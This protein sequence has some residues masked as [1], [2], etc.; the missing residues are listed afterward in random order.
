M[1]SLLI[2]Q[3]ISLLLL[4]V[5]LLA[6]LI[7][8]R[9]QIAYRQRLSERLG[10]VV[11]MRKGGIIL[12]AASV[13]EVMA[14][15]PVV[16]GILSSYPQMPLTI[17]TFTPT[18]SAQVKKQFGERVQ[19]CYIPLD[20]LLSV[21]LFLS[22]LKPKLLILMETELWP[23]LIHSSQRRKIPLLLINARLSQK[24]LGS[25]QKL[26]WLISPALK[27]FHRV[28]A[29][30]EENRDRFIS[31]G[32]IPERVSHSGNLKYDIHLTEAL[33]NK[34][35]EL[36]KLHIANHRV[37]VAGSTHQGE[38][39]LILKAFMEVKELY[40]DLL[41][42]IVPRHPERFDKVQDLCQ[43]Q[44]LSV[45]RRS[46]N[47][48]INEQ[49]DV[50]LVD[51]LGELLAFYGIAD[52]CVVAGSFFDVGGHNPL[53]PALFSK[54]II[55]GPNMVNF[56]DVCEQLLRAEGIVQLES[57]QQLQHQLQHLLGARDEAKSLGQNAQLLLAKNQGAAKRTQAEIEQ[58]INL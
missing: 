37:I 50:W 15:K 26:R 54:P 18:G 23:Q 53:E 16:E 3:L 6:L 33:E 42:A 38:E 9:K 21:N 17:T 28:L 4:P 30:S 34:V 10:W 12:H 47:D 51:T 56:T 58:L 36:R 2:Y 48:E 39:S 35:D 55:V 5:L 22:R 29:Q 49:T 41:L 14:I 32:A 45:A 43:Q 44:G 20:N 13:G 27:K 19:H 11:D 1:I 40:P 24:S 31:L 57:N 25:Y 7:R 52:I 46:Q 8:S